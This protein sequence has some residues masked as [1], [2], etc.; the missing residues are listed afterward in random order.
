MMKDKKEKEYTFTIINENVVKRLENSKA[1]YLPKKKINIPKDKQWNMKVF[2]GALRKG[3]MEGESP[4]KIAKKLFPEIM[5]KTDFTGKTKEEIYGKGGIIAKNK[6]SAIRNART[7]VTGAENSG[8]LDSYKELAKQ[9]VIQ[10]K[11]WIATP[12][13][14]TRPSHI[15]IDGEEQDIDKPFSN[16]CMF[17]GDGRGPA[18]E[19]WNCRC[20]MGDHIIGFQKADGSISRVDYDRDRTIH[21]EQMEEEKSNRSPKKDSKATTEHKADMQ[22]LKDIRKDLEEEALDIAESLA[23]KQGITKEEARSR[24]KKLMGFQSTSYLKRFIKK[25]KRK[26]K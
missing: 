11:E 4:R 2:E 24:A 15:D 9:G 14:R 19:V 10:K 20:S 5:R 3:I 8:R 21:D 18:E 26:K 17:P 13:D 12:D 25:Y 23:E 22:K 6:N 7:M 1:I 16:G